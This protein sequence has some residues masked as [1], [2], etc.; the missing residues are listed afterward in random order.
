L[1]PSF[2]ASGAGGTIVPPQARLDAATWLNARTSVE[3][4][5]IRHPVI[6]T[7]GHHPTSDYAERFWLPVIGPSALWAHRRLTAGLVADHSGYQLDLATL[8]REI[9]LGAGTGR[10]SPIVRTLARLVDFHLAEIIDDRLGVYTSLPP[11]T[12]RQTDRLP[13]HLAE[14]HRA[15]AIRRHDRSPYAARLSAEVSR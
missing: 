12:R 6:E 11:L 1:S 5:P 15:L 4:I 2:G 7:L 8:S 9:G 10:H 14:R 3:V 13:D